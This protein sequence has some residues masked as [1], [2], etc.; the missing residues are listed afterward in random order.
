MPNEGL[1]AFAK[2]YGYVRFFHPSDAAAEADWDAL[3]RA[4]VSELLCAPDLAGAELAAALTRMLAPVAPTLAIYPKGGAPPGTKLEGS[5]PTVAW[6]HRGFGLGVFGGG[7]E[8]ARTGRARRQAIGRG[9]AAISRMIDVES[10]GP[11]IIRLRGRIRVDPRG[12]EDHGALWLRVDGPRDEASFFDN[13]SDRPVRSATWTEVEIEAPLADDAA[14]VAF[15]AIASCEGAVYFADLS[16][17][18]IDGA[19]NH[20]PIGLDNLS[21]DHG[22]TAIWGGEAPDFVY[23][24]L[25]EGE[26]SVLRMAR[27]FR[28]NSRTLFNERPDDGECLDL[29]L[30][31][32]LRVRL[33]VSLPGELAVRRGE[34]GPEASGDLDRVE[35]T[36]MAATI[37][38]WNVLA[39]F[40]P[41]F[42]IIGCNWDAALDGA[43][44]TAREVEDE[45][46]LHAA[47]ERLVARLRDGQARVLGP[48]LW[49]APIRLARV[50]GRVV[51]S[52]AHPSTELRVGDEIS[53]VDGVEIGAALEAGAARCSGSAQAIEAA[54]LDEA[55]VSE[56]APTEPV[57]LS[58]V[59]EGQRLD[60]EVARSP[61]RPPPP[62]RRDEGVSVLDSGVYVV[63]LAQVLWPQI[64]AHLLELAVAPG[65]VFD[66]RRCTSAK[67][68]FLAH[69][70]RRLERRDW[71]YVPRYIYPDQIERTWEAF[72]LPVPLAQP[73]IAGEVAFLIGPGTS[74]GAETVVGFVHGY[75]LGTLVGA[76]TAGA[77]GNVNMFSVP[78]GFHISFTGMLVTRLD[79]EQNH[80]RGFAP[81]VAVAPTR[82]G[83]AAGRDEVL[84]AA[85]AK[86]GG[87]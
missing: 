83:L 59:R 55:R 6:Q 61:E 63:D 25:R 28:T 33:P 35:V 27:R 78:G 20:R 52:V 8:S 51:V 38:A 75:E 11:G 24:V 34:G 30:G 36:A 49:V 50:E 46:G 72:G 66:L 43:L 77:N 74:G 29:E 79:G 9:R 10:F 39:H 68:E 16:L 54:L 53:A 37:V 19:G 62:F 41:Y 31:A 85:L 48:D 12:R 40:Y 23:E 87:S 1:R 60:C 5:G 42:E 86:L 3:V 71:M 7:Y 21:F 44:A 26:R 56:G 47:L 69:L 17:V 18:H 15:G 84:E 64:E 82:A 58:V 73:S 13:M 67:I 45:L 57:T 14:T 80:A 22:N 4:G 32:G 2:L 76:P 65:V 70:M 81:N